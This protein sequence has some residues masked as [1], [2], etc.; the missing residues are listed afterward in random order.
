MAGFPASDRPCARFPLAS[1]EEQ[2]E[3]AKVWQG[4]VRSLG[5]QSDRVVTVIFKRQE[6]SVVRSIIRTYAKL[7][8]E[9][10]NVAFQQMNTRSLNSILDAGGQIPNLRHSKMRPR[11]ASDRS[12]RSMYALYFLFKYAYALANLPQS[13]PNLQPNRI[14]QGN[15]EK[16]ALATY[17]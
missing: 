9:E 7:D 16:R 5:P 4:F 17:S 11:I 6:R 13:V 8:L 3:R 15:S 10:R 12:I 2:N 14:K 1:Q